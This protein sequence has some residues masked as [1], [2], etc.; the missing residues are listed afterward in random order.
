MRSMPLIAGAFPAVGMWSQCTGGRSTALLLLCQRCLLH[1]GYPYANFGGSTL[2]TSAPMTA[3]VGAKETARLS[4]P[5]VV[6]PRRV[7]A[8]ASAD[9]RGSGL[10]GPCTPNRETPAPHCGAL[11][12]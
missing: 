7:C 5:R 6:A 4:R 12:Y 8:D 1:L 2:I 11:L 9:E 10:S 3:G